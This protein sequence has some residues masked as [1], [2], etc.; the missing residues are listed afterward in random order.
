VKNRAAFES[1]YG[2]LGDAVIAGTYGGSLSDGGELVRIV[3]PAG[4][5]VLSFTYSDG[6]YPQT[7][8]EGFSLTVVDPAAA[9]AAWNLKSNWKASGPLGGTPGAADNSPNPGAVV[10]NEVLSTPQAGSTGGD[11]VELRNTTGGDL[12]IGGWYLTNDS[13]NLKRFRIPADTVLPAGGYVVFNQATLGFDISAAGGEVTLSA[14]DRAGALRGYR[15]SV[16]FDAADPGVSFGQFTKTTGGTDFVAMS[17]P[18]P[19]AANAAPLVGPVIINELMF[20]PGTG[21]A[22]YIELRNLTGS[23]VVLNDPANPAGAWKFVDGID[24]VLPAGAT[25]PAFG[26]A[27]VVP[28]DPAAF[29]TIYDIPPGVPIFGPYQ[30]ADGSNNLANTGE[31]LTLFRPVAAGYALAD[32]VNYLPASPWPAGASG[33]GTSIVRAVALDYGNDPANWLEEVAG[34][35][36]GR[37][38]VDFDGPAADVVD[39]T[40][41]PRTSPVDSILIVF[42]EPVQ[43]LDLADLSLKFNGGPNLLTGSETLSTTDNVTWTLSSLA[44]LTAAPGA[45]TLTLNANGSGIVDWAGNDVVAG[46]SD[47]WRVGAA[48]TGRVVGRYVYYNNSRFDGGAN[49]AAD[50]GAIA[51]DKQA[52]LPGQTSTFANYTSYSRGI[53]GVMIDVSGLLADLTAADFVLQVGNNDDPASWAPAPTPLSIS[54]RAGAGTGS[55]DRVTLTFADGSVK[56]KWLRVTVLPTAHTG[57]ASPDVFY[58]GNLVGEIGNDPAGANVNAV[59]LVMVRRNFTAAGKTVPLTNKYDFNRDGKVNALD[60]ALARMGSASGT[61]TRLTAPAASGAAIATAPSTSKTQAVFSQSLVVPQSTS[62]AAGTTTND[63]DV[64]GISGPDVLSR[65]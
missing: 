45:Y 19:G 20:H 64:L 33:T 47:A 57:L 22:E 3:S 7:D 52:L 34:G 44:A 54:R 25:I 13:L 48:P 24:Y 26:Y 43:N 62:T 11:F 1:R 49:G 37:A 61:L 29:R 41:D 30:R 17:S 6:W 9:P 63:R 10:V 2:N 15:E 39:V 18:T 65:A 38:N 27:L 36:P 53:N 31:N 56:N 50:D 4:Q 21:Q 32:R 40:P 58:F 12:D 59:D 51:T 55:S 28:I 5:P 8:G 46:A 60:L 35:S 42:N 14:G 23:E 16:R